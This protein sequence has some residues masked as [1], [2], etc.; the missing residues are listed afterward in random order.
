METEVQVS[1]TFVQLKRSRAANMGAVTKNA[2][3]IQELLTKVQVGTFSDVDLDTVNILLE[4][5]ECR[6]N[7]IKDFNEKN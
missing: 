4:K 3:K 7:L 6:R 5:S 2:P 1:K